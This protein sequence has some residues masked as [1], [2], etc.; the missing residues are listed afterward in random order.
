LPAPATISAPTSA[1]AFGAVA[2]IRRL[3]VVIKAGSA[4]ASG[5]ASRPAK[6]LASP[7]DRADAA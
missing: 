1:A 5:V 7:E 2:T 3:A 4:S 6:R